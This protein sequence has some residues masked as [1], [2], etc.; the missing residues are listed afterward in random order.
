M[1]RARNMCKGVKVGRPRVPAP[2]EGFVV[3]RRVTRSQA[4]HASSNVDMT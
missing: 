2:S 1:R 4:K 3:G